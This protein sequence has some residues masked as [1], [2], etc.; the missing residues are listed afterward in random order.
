MPSGS[1]SAKTLAAWGIHSPAAAAN[2]GIEWPD[3]QNNAKFQDIWRWE[4]DVHEDWIARIEDD[5]PALSAVIEST[6]RAHSEAMAAYL[7]YMAIRIIEMRRV[8]KT[9]GNMY[10]HCDPTASHY[11]KSVMDAVFGVDKFKA[12]ITWRRT[13]A[14]S[15]S[16]SFGNVSDSILFY[17]ND[18]ANL[19]A[20]RV[21]LA[22]EYI[23]S[24]Y[25]HK[26]KR[27]AYQD[28]SHTGPGLS[29]GESGQPWRGY[30]PGVIGRCWSVPKTGKYA[31]WI[32]ENIIPGYK[33]IASVLERLDALDQADMI[34]YTPKGSVPRLK[35]YLEASQGQVPNSVWDDIPPLNSQATE[36]SGYPTQK[37]VALAERII[38]A[39]S[40]PGDV[41]LDCFA[42]CAY[43]PVAAERNGRQ[44]IACD[45]SPRALTVLRRQFAKFQYAVDGSQNAEQPA[46]I[47]AANV[48]TRSPNDLPERTDDDPAERH[49]IK[50]L[51]ERKYKVPSSLIPEKEMLEYLLKL[52]GYTAWC[53]GFANRRPNG[54]HRGN[55][56]QLPPRPHRPQEQGRLQPDLEPRPAM[57]G[58]QHPQEQPPRSP[59][60]VPRGNR[61][62]RRD[63]GKHH[64]RPDKLSL[65]TTASRGLLRCRQI[66]A[67]MTPVQELKFET[68]KRHK[69]ERMTL[70]DERLNYGTLRNHIIP[71]FHMRNFAET[72]AYKDMVYLYNL[73]NAKKVRNYKPKRLTVENAAVQ[74]GFYTDE[75]ESRLAEEYESPAAP[76][77][78]KMITGQ[79]LTFD[80][81]EA[82]AAYL[83][84][85]NTRSPSLLTSITEMYSLLSGE[86]INHIKENFSTIKEALVNRG[87]P[88]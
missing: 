62:R 30:D 5:Y 10:L 73:E 45:I 82:V 88:N 83:L 2:A 29:Q 77:I 8:L 50:E 1:W 13:F 85:Y 41:V 44:W 43:V 34:H 36:R 74:K 60:G 51:P 76:A 40:N 87:E 20:I 70:K 24:H 71:Q 49:D 25:R 61:Q 14:H 59:G 63:A 3:N 16:R 4:S 21:P 66:P 81:R 27:G 47:V 26:D 79:A 7:V 84:S 38:L 68:R 9:T 78:T 11:L 48:I 53:C 19:D 56:Q 64:R 58:P 31:S 15:D 33:G 35:R 37:P 23:K 65:G 22:P 42:G 28:D 55:H 54:G 46:L 12:E 69:R 18:V 80:E 6:R 57:P 86:Y 32:D 52:S 67:I 39:S 72:I 17:G 75:Y